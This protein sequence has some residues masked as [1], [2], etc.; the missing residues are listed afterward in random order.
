MQQIGDIIGIW[1]IQKE[2]KTSKRIQALKKRKSR[3]KSIYG[4]DK[5]KTQIMFTNSC[6]EV[7]ELGKKKAKK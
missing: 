1:I 4:K 2:K 5:E 7:N 6:H 3:S